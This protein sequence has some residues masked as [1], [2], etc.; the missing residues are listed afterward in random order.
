MFP[1]MKRK[2]LIR[3]YLKLAR[4][5]NAVLTGVSPVM[6]AVAMAQFDIKYLFLLF[7]V[8]FFGHT[9]GFI[10][11]DLCDYKIDK[12]SKDISDRPLISGTIS[13]KKACVV[14]P[15]VYQDQP[16]QI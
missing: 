7:L 10:I 14:N 12:Y 15:E 1:R 9:Y 5:Y 8:G 3:E 6:G 13:M 16:A 11:N 4:S 2:M